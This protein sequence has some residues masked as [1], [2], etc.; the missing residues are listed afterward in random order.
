MFMS[1]LGFG[2]DMLF[3]NFHIGGMLLLFSDMTY[4]FGK[5]TMHIPGCMALLL[6][7]SDCYCIHREEW[8]DN[9]NMLSDMFEMPDVNFVRPHMVV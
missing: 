5:S 8:V 7:D 6:I 4:H 1:L 2:M 3:S 9:N